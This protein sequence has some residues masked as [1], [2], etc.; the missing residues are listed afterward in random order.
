MVD[1]PIW[2]VL[3]Q[4]YTAE[5]SSEGRYQLLEQAFHASAEELQTYTYAEQQA[6]SIAAQYTDRSL[7][8]LF[9]REKTYN[10]FVRKLSEKSWKENI[11]P[12]IEEKLV[13]VM[14]IVCRE[15]LPFYQK[16]PGSKLLLPHHAYYI[17]EE[18]IKTR[19]RFR[20]DEKS[21]QYRLYA[22]SMGEE[23]DLI[24]KKP[25]IVLSSSPAILLAGMNVWRF[26]NLEARRVLPFTHKHTIHVETT[27]TMKYLHNILL[28]VARFHPIDVEGIEIKKIRE[29]CSPVLSIEDSI[30]TDS[31]LYLR[32]RYGE[33][34]F[35]R[36]A[37]QPGEKEVWLE[38]SEGT[39]WIRILSRNYTAE[40]RAIHWLNRHDLQQVSDTLFRLSPNSV[41]PGISGWMLHYRQELA[42][43]FELISLHQKAS[44]HLEEMQLEQDFTEERDWFEL[45]IT[46]C[47]DD[48]RI[49]FVR[50]RRHILNGQREYTL[51]DGRIVLLP[52]EWFT[53]YPPL[54]EQAEE[55]K[56]VLRIPSSFV[57]IVEPLLEENQRKRL[58]SYTQKEK[59]PTP[60]GLKAR[61]RPYQQTGFSWLL[62]LNKNGF[63]A[64]LA[65]DMGLGKTLQTLALLQQIYGYSSVNESSPTVGEEKEAPSIADEKG[66]FLLFTTGE[67]T[68]NSSP[69]SIPDSGQRSLSSTDTPALPA[70]LIV[71]PT[72]LLHN[73][74]QEIRRFTGLRMVCLSN[75]DQF[76][77]HNLKG[78]FDKQ[79]LV[80]TTYGMLR[81][82]ITTLAAYRFEYVILDESQHIKNSDSVTFR[83]AISLRS[84]HRL[85][86]T[87]TPIEN[88]LKDLWAQFRFIQ[89]G[90][91]GSEKD[92]QAHY[93]QPIR[94]GNALQ[95]L[96]LKQLISPFILRRNKKEVAPELPALTEEVILCDM[97]SAQEEV[98]KE[99]KNSLRN[100]LLHETEREQPAHSLT[101]LNGIT[102]LRQLA[103][104]PRLV[105]PD[106][107]HR[108]GK[109][110]QIL[111]AVETLQSEGH[112][113]LIFSSFVKHL[114][115]VAD[116]FRQRHWQYA[117]LT[118]STKEREKEIQHFSS[119]EQVIAFLISLKAGGVGL[120][121]TEADYVFIID[122]W[123]NPAAENQAIARAH[124]IGQDKQVFVY[125]FITEATIEE[126]ILQLQEEKQRLADT[127][128]TDNDPFLSLSDAEWAKL[129]EM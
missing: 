70:S 60:A 120:N 11:R 57:G 78:Y 82:N 104:H 99:E 5:P 113:V 126:K 42:S 118:G 4:P 83:S 52:E 48:L 29:V 86:L 100:L 119:S 9:S 8:K 62:H 129:L 49:P 55:K 17:P 26:N 107:E 56:S 96:R 114:E 74:R 33:D 71:V 31:L 54:L 94:M 101:V 67:E 10:D 1:H 2:G 46:V 40:Q 128:V 88:S 91:L 64:C 24:E 97:S 98:Y 103:C 27:Q 127:F 87:G 73:W 69:A 51:P 75:N 47:I 92:F 37:T 85:V 125:R 65:D 111:A 12:F 123:W 110:E 102:R 34:W 39:P 80:V 50:F 28:P 15:K 117:M 25:V 3:I 81:H 13:A 35:D 121:L 95:A 90:L 23:L 53:M 41:L 44:Y 105:L 122:P 30:Y 18:N 66:Q 76:R 20:I 14:D 38:E 116:A 84:N 112:K 43:R 72:S 59:L 45:R 79:Q 106:Y 108:S 7:M 6:V 58:H 115:I 109:L 19:F 61:L 93:I 63:G 36:P 124:R 22:T 16:Q 21:F 89:P 68:Q 32:Y 77:L